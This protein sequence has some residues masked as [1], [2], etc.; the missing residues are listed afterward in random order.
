[1]IAFDPNIAD[2]KLD[3]DTERMVRVAAGDR[4]AFDELVRRNY[5]STVRII[6]AMMGSTSQSEDIAQEVFLRTYRSR[7]R[8]LPTARFATFLGTIIRNTVL[9]AKRSQSRRLVRS[10]AVAAQQ[11]RT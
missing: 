6:S 4:R 9:N 3:P 10:P 1:M 5:S 8:Y 2:A 7:V 11:R